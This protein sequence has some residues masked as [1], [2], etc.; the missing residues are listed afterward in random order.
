MQL[1]LD[2][3][4]CQ[5]ILIEAALA[6]MY[7]MLGNEERYRFFYERAKSKLGSEGDLLSYRTR[8]AADNALTRTEAAMGR[9]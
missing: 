6:E 5:E 4:H 9:G 8:E 3:I 1:P 2:K 7:A